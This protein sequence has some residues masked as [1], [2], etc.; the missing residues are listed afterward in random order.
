MYYFLIKVALR[1]GGYRWVV[2]LER[3]A[4]FKVPSTGWTYVSDT[5]SKRDVKFIDLEEAIFYCRKMGFLCIIDVYLKFLK[6]SGFGY[7]VQYP[8]FRYAQK[9]SYADNFKWKGQPKDE[10]DF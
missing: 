3:K 7:E 5:Q 6:I 4:V 8:H 10:E 1:P 2:Q 9:K